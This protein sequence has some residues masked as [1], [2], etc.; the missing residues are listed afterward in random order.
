MKKNGKFTEY[1]EYEDGSI[2]IARKYQ[3]EIADILAKKTVPNELL[4]AVADQCFNLLSV[5]RKEEFK[6]WDKL[7]EDFGLDDT[8]YTYTYDGQTKLIIRNLKKNKDAI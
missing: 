6:F 1:E 4:Q 3:K 2:K 8:I 7:R 5:I